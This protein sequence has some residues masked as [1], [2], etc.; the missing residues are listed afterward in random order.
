[1]S[2]VSPQNPVSNSYSGGEQLNVRALWEFCQYTNDNI[3]SL[4][5]VVDTHRSAQFLQYE[6]AM[7]FI[8]WLITTN[9]KVLDEFQAVA[10][11]LDS[12]EPR[13]DGGE[14]SAMSSP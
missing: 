5:S 1:M 4:K 3:N 8:N 2:L 7:R 13:D 6:K 10:K 12:L 14:S 11:T 9:P